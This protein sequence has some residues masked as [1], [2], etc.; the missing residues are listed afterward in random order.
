MF[1]HL[2]TPIHLECQNVVANHS[3]IYAMLSLIALNKSYDVNWNCSSI[4][5]AFISL[6]FLGN[7]MQAG[8]GS[9]MIMAIGIFFKRNTI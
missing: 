1:I 5:F 8:L 6:P 4:L 7:I 9:V 2:S 3:S